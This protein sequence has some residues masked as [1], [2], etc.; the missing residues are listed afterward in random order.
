MTTI[1]KICCFIGV[2]MLMMTSTV[3]VDINGSFIFIWLLVTAF[4]LTA[5]RAW[6]IFKKH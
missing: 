2:M 6:L 1:E 4:F 5:G 3:A